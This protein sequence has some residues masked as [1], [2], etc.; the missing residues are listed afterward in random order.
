MNIL[1]IRFVPSHAPAWC[2]LA[3][4]QRQPCP[5][6]LAL[7]CTFLVCDAVAT[8]AMHACTSTSDC[9]AF[10]PSARLPFQ[11]AP[12][13]RLANS[14]MFAA[15]CDTRGPLLRS[16]A[17]VSPCE[18]LH[19]SLALPLP[20]VCMITAGGGPLGRH[21][22]CTCKDCA[23]SGEGTVTHSPVLNARRCCVSCE[24]YV[25]G[26]LKADGCS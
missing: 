26:E 5:H 9:L 10:L 3:F 15:P 16:P 8:L 4:L 21:A 19:T 20:V 12:V 25:S 1:H 22:S 2:L 11:S 13:V 23:A 17:A 14:D 18:L 7:P 24:C 6:A